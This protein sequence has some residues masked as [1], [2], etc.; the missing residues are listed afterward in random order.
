MK[1]NIVWAVFDRNG[2]I[3]VWGGRRLA[4]YTS[5]HGKEI[6]F[7]RSKNN[8]EDFVVKKVEIR[9]IK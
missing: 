8:K 6:S 9:P 3:R 5:N 4:I 1:K 2:N 7:M